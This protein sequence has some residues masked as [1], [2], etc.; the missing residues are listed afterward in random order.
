MSDYLGFTY[1]VY[2]FI[3]FLQLN[4]SPFKDLC[5]PMGEKNWCVFFFFEIKRGKEPTLC[6]I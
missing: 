3:V 5:L 6:V 2:G 1:L 4:L